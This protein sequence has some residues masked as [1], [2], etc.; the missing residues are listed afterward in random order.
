MVDFQAADGAHLEVRTRDDGR[1][2]ID[3]Q[4][5]VEPQVEGARGLRQL[6]PLQRERQPGTTNTTKLFL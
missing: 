1:A 5:R 3:S 2:R 4:V 6:H